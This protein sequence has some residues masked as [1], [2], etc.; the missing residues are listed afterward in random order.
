MVG[1]AWKWSEDL[2][3]DQ[4]KMEEL[5]NGWQSSEGAGLSS[6][7]VEGSHKRLVVLKNRLTSLAVAREGQRSSAMACGARRWRAK[8]KNDRRIL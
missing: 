8:L 6:K 7:M 2:K 3:D 5:D 4:R 1:G